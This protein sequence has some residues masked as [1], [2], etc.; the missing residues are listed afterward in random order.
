MQTQDKTGFKRVVK[1][2]SAGIQAIVSGAKVLQS[3]RIMVIRFSKGHLTK[4]TSAN[5]CHFKYF[6]HLWVIHP[7][8]SLVFI[9]H[10]QL[11]HFSIPPIY[12]S[13]LRC[14]HLFTCSTCYSLCLIV[15]RNGPPPVGVLPPES[16]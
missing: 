3:A 1:E 7:N 2:Q 8:N 4:K 6:F 13:F 9:L 16:C 12:A 15:L 11:I 14:Y 5:V 10:T